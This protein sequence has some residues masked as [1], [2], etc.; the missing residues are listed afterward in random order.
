MITSKS[1]CGILTPPVQPSGQFTTECTRYRCAGRHRHPV[2]GLLHR[3]HVSGWSP[4]GF[5]ATVTSGQ[6]NVVVPA[7]ELITLQYVPAQGDPK[8]LDSDDSPE[9]C[10]PPPVEP[11][12]QFTVECTATGAQADVGTLS[13]GDFPGGFFR[14]VA[15]DFAVTVTSGQQNVTVPADSA[16]A[17]EYVVNGDDI[18]EPR[19]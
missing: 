8:T 3:G 10:P 7:D 6:Q 1:D 12:G 4:T 16:I 2:P 13:A 17:L 11:S 14:L 19:Q 18:K 15:D 9:A 5:S